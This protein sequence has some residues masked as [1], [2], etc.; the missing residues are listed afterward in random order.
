MTQYTKPTVLPQWGETAGGADVLQP[1]NAEIQ[2]GWP[3]TSVPPSR[4]RF[5]WILKYLAQGVRY[6]MQMGIPL[7]DSAEDYPVNARV[8]GSNGKTYK[9]LQTSISQDPTTATA[10]WQLW[11]TD[12]RDGQLQLTTA[13]TTAGTAPN[14]TISATPAPAALSANLRLRVKFHA[15][16]AGSDVLN[17]NALGNKSLKQ[18]DCTGAKAPAIIKANQLVDIEYDGTD[19]V[20][21][22]PIVPVQ[23][24]EVAFFAMNSAPAGYIKANGA[25]ISRTVYATLFAAIG[26]TFGVGDGTTTFNVPD[27]RGEFLRGWD[28]ARGVDSS[29]A[30]GSAQSGQ[31][32]SHTHTL[33][34]VTIYDGGGANWGIPV[35]SSGGNPNA[36]TGAH[37]VSNI[38]ANGGTEARPRNIALLACIRYQ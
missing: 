33:T 25:A 14:F 29:R 7:W 23:A 20:L 4:K 3:L 36:P 35:T 30:F 28:D 19:L 34:Q 15:S 11:A 32:L 26:T 12:G 37:P 10:Y 6:M 18:Y 1:S 24:G 27:L 31:N 9:A 17:I 8:M 2:A 13:F 5:N 22:D 16:G 38:A 21:L